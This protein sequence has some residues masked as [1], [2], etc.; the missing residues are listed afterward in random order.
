[1]W[2]LR[3]R[4]TMAEADKF[5]R[6]AA[7]GGRLEKEWPR[8]VRAR[9]TKHRINTLIAEAEASNLLPLVRCKAACAA[10]WNLGGRQAMPDDAG[11][12][13][14]R[15]ALVLDGVDAQTSQALMGRGLPAERI[16]SPNVV[17]AVAEALSGRGISSWCGRVQDFLRST[18]V[19]GALDLL[20]LDYTGCLASRASHLRPALRALRPHGVLACT[21]S[22][23]H[24]PVE[25]D[26]SYGFLP[27]QPEGW[28]HAHAV[29][30]LGRCLLEA[31]EALGRSV[32]GAGLSG[33]NDYELFDNMSAAWATRSAGDASETT[34]ELVIRALEEES[35]PALAEALASWADEPNSELP[36]LRKGVATVAERVQRACQGGV[37]GCAWRSG[38]EGRGTPHCLLGA[39]GAVQD[40]DLNM[41]RKAAVALKQA[42]SSRG[43]AC[44]PAALTP[45]P[46][47]SFRRSMLVYPEEMMFF[48]VRCG[49]KVGTV[50]QP[51]TDLCMAKASFLWLFGYRKC[52]SC[53][54]YSNSGWFD[55][56]DVW[57]CEE[58]QMNC[59]LDLFSDEPVPAES[60]LRCG[61]RRVRELPAL[62]SSQ[63]LV[64][65]C[66]LVK[67]GG[68]AG[69]FGG[70][71]VLTGTGMALG[72]LWSHLQGG[73]GP[74]SLGTEPTKVEAAAA[75]AT[76]AAFADPWV[77]VVD[78]RPGCF[79]PGDPVEVSESSGRGWR[80][81]VKCKAGEGS[82]I[83]EDQSQTPHTVA[84]DRL[85]V[86][87]LVASVL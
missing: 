24:S 20:F 81:V 45:C 14:G 9:R 39:N 49:E 65:T 52:E 51:A 72:S 8:I 66:E 64:C 50:R 70:R 3:C 1:M 62:A 55:A 34:R 44:S 47:F 21:F 76:E 79:I 11:G 68:H 35:I 43:S 5:E 40:K 31:A 63:L 15:L 13:D 59:V 25:D 71:L 7:A 36:W 16:L 74:K 4:G 73:S 6:R 29:H 69:L 56:D 61:I 30:A 75:A 78:S 41:L 27:P 23:R 58:C 86:D 53:Q 48:M 87:E 46:A 10:E 38:D 28:S 17:P 26:F 19:S 60:W 2:S 54:E 32:E 18:E 12:E 82:Y 84:A 33:L 22:M 37:L 77:V 57:Y 85:R 80:G 83:V 42:G 67:V